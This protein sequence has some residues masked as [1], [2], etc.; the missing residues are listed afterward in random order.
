MYLTDVEHALI[1]EAQRFRQAFDRELGAMLEGSERNVILPPTD[2]MLMMTP[3]RFA[4]KIGRKALVVSSRPMT[5]ESNGALGLGS[6]RA[7]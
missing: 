2:E 6:P 1:A 4:R 7:P 5:F 3:S